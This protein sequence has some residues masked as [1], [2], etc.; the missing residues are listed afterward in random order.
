MSTVPAEKSS[1]LTVVG[2]S[3]NDSNESVRIVSCA[4]C[5]KCRVSEQIGSDVLGLQPFVVT[6]NC[7]CC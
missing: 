3:V 4:D 2:T 5:L 6:M 7:V 1:S